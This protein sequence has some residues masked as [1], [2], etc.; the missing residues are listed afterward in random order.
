M[1]IEYLEA[2]PVGDSGVL[3]NSPALASQCRFLMGISEGVVYPEMYIVRSGGVLLCIRSRDMYKLIADGLLT[4]GL[5][6]QGPDGSLQSAELLGDAVLDESSPANAGMF[7][8]GT[9]RNGRTRS[10]ADVAVATLSKDMVGLLDGADFGMRSRAVQGVM[11]AM[12]ADIWRTRPR[13]AKTL[14]PVL[15][16]GIR[17]MWLASGFAGMAD[18]MAEKKKSG[19]GKRKTSGG[20]SESSGAPR[21]VENAPSPEEGLA[22]LQA[23]QDYMNS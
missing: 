14:G 12:T 3:V 13:N 17:E 2:V 7:L 18:K 5:V 4:Y 22:A 1:Q 15:E 23:F 10:G 11:S 9:W 8:T 16:E 19:S 20:R 21:Q 6:N